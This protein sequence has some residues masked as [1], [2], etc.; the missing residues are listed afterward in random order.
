MRV[1]LAP[2]RIEL[3]EV[4]VPSPPVRRILALWH[5]RRD[6]QDRSQRRHDMLLTRAHKRSR[7]CL[8]Y[9]GSALL[10]CPL[11]MAGSRRTPFIG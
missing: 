1:W 7:I 8:L 3:A 5:R 2:V 10:F 9:M 4:V 11:P 6:C